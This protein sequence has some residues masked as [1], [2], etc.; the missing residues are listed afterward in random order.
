MPSWRYRSRAVFRGWCVILWLGSIAVT[1]V[2]GV[3]QDVAL[4]AL[5][6]EYH[7]GMGFGLGFS[8]RMDLGA[9]G[10]Q[11]AEGE[12]GWGGAYHNTYWVAPVERLTVVYMTQRLPAGDVDDHGKLHALIYQAVN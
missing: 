1:Q 6:V 11:G 8:I 3:I 4:V 2:A 9:A 12:F 5:S 7:T 10:Q